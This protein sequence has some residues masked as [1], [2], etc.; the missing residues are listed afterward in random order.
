MEFIIGA[1][2]VWFGAMVL[3]SAGMLVV[4]VVGELWVWFVDVLRMFKDVFN[5]H[6][7]FNHE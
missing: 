6:S 4:K 7:W 3:I 2:L 5:W 1:V